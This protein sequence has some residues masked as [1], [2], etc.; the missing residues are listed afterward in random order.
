MGLFGKAFFRLRRSMLFLI[1]PLIGNQR[2]TAKYIKM[3]SRQGV[4]VSPFDTC[5]FIATSVHFDFYRPEMIHIG[6]NVYL[7]HD[8]IIL[9]HD[10][11]VVTAFNSGFVDPNAGDLY[12]TKDVRIGN[13]V[14]VGMRSILMPGCRIGNNCII[15]AGSVVKGNIPSGTVWAGNPARE[16]CS[17]E[18]YRTKLE[19]HGEIKG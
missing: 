10:Q 3:L 2:Y 17:M 7:T 4:D 5:G 14:F 18:D 12:I 1:R 16:I 9:V 15:G 6:R 13:N 11:S 8:V 19:K